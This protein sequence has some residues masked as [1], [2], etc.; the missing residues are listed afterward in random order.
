MDNAELRFEPMKDELSLQ[1]QEFCHGAMPAG[2]MK[3]YPSGSVLT[4]AYQGYAHQILDMEVREDDI[5]VITFP[6]SGTTWTQEMV[7]LLRNNLDFNK[8]KSTYLHHRFPQLEL[9]PICGDQLAD[10][11]PDNIQF[12]SQLSSPRFIKS[13]LPIQLL[14]RQIWTKKPKLIYVFR[15]PKDVALSYYHHYRVWKNYTGSIELFLEGFIQDKVVF[16]PFWEQVLSFW[17]IRNKPN[18]IFNTYEEMKQD[19]R[20][21]VRRV[22]EFLG[23]SYS[24]DE[25]TTLLDHLSFSSMKENKAVN[26]V[27]EMPQKNK[28]MHFMRQGETGSWKKEMDPQF[29]RR[30]DEWT[31][32]K[33]K[34]TDF[35][36]PI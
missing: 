11:I 10:R 21:I 23:E 3:V 15:N 19:L 12:L 32:K 8:A 27:D 2:E 14:P 29:A 13:H 7:W 33:L 24:E 31:A 18:I 34:G 4:R 16:S 30:F 9:K 35:P 22:E 1:L 20:S 5:W 6:K 26:Y 28:H 36:L 17:N 25:V